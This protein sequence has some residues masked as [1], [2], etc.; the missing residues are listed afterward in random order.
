[1]IN[2]GVQPGKKVL[3]IFFYI[4]FLKHFFMDYINHINVLFV[5][6]V[7]DF[8]SKNKTKKKKTSKELGRFI[9]G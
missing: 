9:F 2:L 5:F 1:M 6:K 8:F 3:M 4:L 7:R